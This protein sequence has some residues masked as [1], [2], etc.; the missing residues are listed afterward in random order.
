MLMPDFFKSVS[1]KSM[2]ACLSFPEIGE[3]P[4]FLDGA[5]TLAIVK[6]HNIREYLQFFRFSHLTFQFFVVN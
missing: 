1:Q 4:F 3:E 5:F 6:I 2:I